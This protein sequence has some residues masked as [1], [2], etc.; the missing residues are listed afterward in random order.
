MLVVITLVAVYA[1]G[2]A[3]EHFFRKDPSAVVIDELV[4]TLVTFWAIPLSL[5]TMIIG[6]LLFRFFDIIKPLGI[7]KCENL[8]GGFGIVMDDVVAG[9][10]SAII[11][12]VIIVNLN[13]L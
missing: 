8:S 5:N 11:L 10:Y 6:F 13:F 1:S 2:R 9:L 12:R 7:K 4:G 3:A